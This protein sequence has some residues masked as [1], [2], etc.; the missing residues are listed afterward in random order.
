MWRTDDDDDRRHRGSGTRAESWHPRR[1]A[2][3]QLIADLCAILA[4]RESP[5][6][7]VLERRE[8]DKWESMVMA[9][10]HA[11]EES[12]RI[13]ALAMT[14]G[15][16]ECDRLR[17]V[18][19]AWERLEAPVVRAL[20][21]DVERLTRERDE[22]QEEQQRANREW[23]RRYDELSR[24]NQGLYKEANRQIDEL[25]TPVEMPADIV[26]TIRTA[27]AKRWPRVQAT[28]CASCETRPRS[29][30]CDGCV[31]EDHQAARIAAAS[32]QHKAR[33]EQLVGP[34]DDDKDEPPPRIA[35]DEE[36]VAAIFGGDPRRHPPSPAP[37]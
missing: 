11:W 35:L 16:D 31:I 23:Q 32:A 27:L 36:E 8:R 29:A 25:L 1:R 10:R 6:T 19:A 37:T 13:G 2:H 33:L 18:V 5:A 26:Q 15:L 30:W 24:A 7:S 4:A 22:A 21:A 17:S 12:E 28:E 14:A 9:W 20:R 3:R 34:L